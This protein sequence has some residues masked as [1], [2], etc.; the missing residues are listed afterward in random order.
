MKKLLLQSEKVCA[1]LSIMCICVGGLGVR[2]C[3]ASL[4][5]VSCSQRP[6]LFKQTTYGFPPPQR[7][8]IKIIARIYI[9]RYRTRGYGCDKFFLILF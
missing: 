3:S 8:A 1:P 9:L 4:V 7:I 2:I 5:K 6:I